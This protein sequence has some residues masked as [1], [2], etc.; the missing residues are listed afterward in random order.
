VPSTAVE[1]F[2]RFVDDRFAPWRGRR[3][4]DALAYV[5]SALGDHGLVWFILGV[6]R[7]RR[8]G[9]RRATAV[10]AV[11]FT[12]LVTPVVNAGLKA[13]VGRGRPERAAA[14][15]GP[16]R[17]PRTA[18]FPSGHALAAWCAATLLADG[19]PLAPAYYVLAAVV[20]GSRVH[21]GLHHAS[22]VVAGSLLGLCLGGLGRLAFPLPPPSG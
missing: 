18:S 7:G 10:R 13:A 21:V 17:I 2:D 4:V 16:V 12:G 3:V 22:D 1:S 20:S 19:D 9:P 14:R 11:V 8:P 15:P 6:A 5:A